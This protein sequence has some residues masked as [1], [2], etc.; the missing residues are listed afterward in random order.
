M[1]WVALGAT[2]PR[3]FRLFLIYRW[4]DGNPSSIFPKFFILL[5]KHIRFGFTKEHPKIL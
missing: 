3:V 5:R 4:I 2:K 1:R